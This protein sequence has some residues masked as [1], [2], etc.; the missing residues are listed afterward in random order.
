MEMEEEEEEE[1]VLPLDL[2]DG[3]DLSIFA[4]LYEPAAQ[5][6]AAPTPTPSTSRQLSEALFDG[7]CRVCRKRT[8]EVCQGCKVVRY[9]GEGCQSADAER[10]NKG[11]CSQCVEEDCAEKL[12]GMKAKLMAGE[13][14][15]EQR[16]VWAGELGCKKALLSVLT[17]GMS[18]DSVGD[19][20]VTA[21]LA[22]AGWGHVEA[23][24]I[25]SGKRQTCTW[26]AMAATRH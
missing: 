11:Q 5:A 7:R 4:Y 10:H 26:W 15:P 9:C 6:P 2:S 25:L 18:V 13:G 12:A 21:T 22:A 8:S 1:E 24:R 14:S 3:H 23:L 20:G 19:N 16:L 17:E